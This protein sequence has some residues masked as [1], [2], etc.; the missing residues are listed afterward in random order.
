MAATAVT[1]YHDQKQPGE[2]RFIW[3]TGSNHS[4]SLKARTGA[5]QNPGGG[6]EVETMGECC[7]LANLSVC[8]YIKPRTLCR[9]DN[10]PQCAGPSHISH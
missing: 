6:S 2:E 5:K 7:L 8:F 1:K 10:H 3:P 9:G 4:P